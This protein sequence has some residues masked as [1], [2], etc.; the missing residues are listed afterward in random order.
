M[1]NIIGSRKRTAQ[2]VMDKK[3]ISIYIKFFLGVFFILIGFCLPFLGLIVMGL[4]GM[5]PFDDFLLFYAGITI[6]GILKLVCIGWGMY[7]IIR[8]I[9]LITK[10]PS[11]TNHA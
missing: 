5:G 2:R 11:K 9:I 8:S 6:L 7:I 4:L 1:L 3:T 10:R